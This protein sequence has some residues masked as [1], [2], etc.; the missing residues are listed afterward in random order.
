MKFGPGWRTSFSTVICLVTFLIGSSPTS[1]AGSFGLN[2][3]SVS[4]LGSAYAGGAAQAEDASTL[5]FNPAGL[6]LL[7]HGELQIGGEFIA[8]SANFQ[9]Q[10]SRLIAPGT[11]FNNEPLTGGNGGDGGVD[12][13]IPNV[14]LSQPLFRSPTYGDLTIGIGLT[15][16]FGLETDYQPDWVGRYVALRTKLIT[17]DIQPTISYRFLDRISI[18]AGLDV[19]YASARLSQAIDFG[20]IG[21]ATLAP[22]YAAI[23]GQLAA[24]GVPPAAISRTVA[25][26]ELAYARAGFVPQGRDGVAEVQGDDWSVGF[27]IGFIF[28]YLKGNELPFFQDGR[29]GFSYRSA[30]DHTIT[31]T[32]QF[33]GVPSLTA[34]GAPVQFPF[35]SAL[36][37]VFFNQNAS[38][39][40]DLPAIYHF[41][42]YQRFLEKFAMMGDIEWTRWNRLQ[43]VDITFSNP[44]TPSNVLNLQYDDAVRYSVG[45]EWYALKQLTFRG[46]FAYDETPIHS[47]ETRT[48]RIPDNNRYFLSAGLRWQPCSF[49]AFDV[50]YAHLFVQDGTV[51]FTDTQGHNLRGKFSDSVDIV[52]AAITFLWGGP[53]PPPETAPSGKSPVGYAK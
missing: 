32:G 51:D 29:F 36:Q 33:R 4:S 28:E 38:A 23:P 17:F 42:L 52:S 35:P 49:V 43:Q 1:R 16:P 41:S 10:G 22:F 27:T 5:F 31:G 46:G 48:P 9:N 34:I 37:D 11:P 44:S 19:Q 53:K 24:L 40:L 13:L 20:E 50:G 47:A 12:H 21:A 39:G 25:A 15:V 30:I 26:T 6:A 2:E 7:N 45:V 14:Y 8:P 3:Q 18:G